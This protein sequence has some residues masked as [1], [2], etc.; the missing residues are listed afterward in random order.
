MASK[1]L[2]LVPNAAAALWGRGSRRL[3]RLFDRSFGR[4][5]KENDRQ[6]DEWTSGELPWDGDEDEKE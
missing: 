4:E 2:V 6:T 5:E 3:R 1:T